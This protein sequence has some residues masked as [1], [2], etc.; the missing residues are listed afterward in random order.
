M[1]DV[2]MTATTLYFL[3]NHAYCIIYYNYVYVNGI[4]NKF[5]YSKFIYSQNNYCAIVI[6]I[7][8]KYI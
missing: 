4:R 1:K 2:I 3:F 7:V 6:I 8:F 5:M